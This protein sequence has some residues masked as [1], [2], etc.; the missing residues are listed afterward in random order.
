MEEAGSCASIPE[1]LLLS[2]KMAHLRTN[3][4]MAED[5]PIRGPAAQAP[6][7]PKKNFI[8]YD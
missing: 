7:W 8:H 5:K 6:R 2:D 3:K 1:F 4:E